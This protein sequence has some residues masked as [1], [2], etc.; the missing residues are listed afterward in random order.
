[1]EEEEEDDS[2]DIMDA[3]LTPSY[4]GCVQDLL[5]CLEYSLVHGLYDNFPDLL[6]A[7][8]KATLL[9]NRAAA[10]GKP[11]SGSIMLEVNQRSIKPSFWKQW[12]KSQC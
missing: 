1:M 3:A 10:L 9:R 4:P 2:V 8:Y 6:R 7:K 11:A 5:H 12:N